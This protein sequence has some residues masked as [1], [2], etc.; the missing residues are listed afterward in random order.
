MDIVPRCHVTSLTDEEAYLS[1]A[2]FTQPREALYSLFATNDRVR[3]EASGHSTG[4]EAEVPA[5]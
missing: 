3:A 4:I 2:G 5:T 1:R